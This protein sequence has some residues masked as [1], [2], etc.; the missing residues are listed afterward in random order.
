MSNFVDNSGESPLTIDTLES[1]LIATSGVISGCDSDEKDYT[2]IKQLWKDELK[3][4]KAKPEETIWYSNAAEFWDDPEKCP[5]TDD[6]VLQGFGEITPADTIGSNEFLDGL[7]ASNPSL[8]FNRAADCGAGIGRV[9]KN[10]LLPR[11][12]HV[13]LIEQSPRLSAAT[14]AYINSAEDQK[15]ITCIV[16]GLQDFAPPPNTYDVIWIQWV[17]GH[18]FDLDAIKFFKRC[19]AGLKPGGLVVLK[20]NISAP[21]G[22]TFVV[23]KDDS[24]VARSLAYMK[25]LI[26]LAGLKIDVETVQAGFP[27][28]LTPVVMLSMSPIDRV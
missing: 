24:S 23:D 12:L 9:T 14:N 2:S 8:E 4:N 21:G 28:E 17:I 26:T 25:L 5:I 19:A 22:F 20:D 13:D 3:P 1:M 6:G 10:F 11:F 18:I 27:E 7:A 15:R 16:Q